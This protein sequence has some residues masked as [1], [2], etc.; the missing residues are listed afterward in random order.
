MKIAII[1]VSILSMAA[2]IGWLIRKH[3]ARQDRLQFRQKLSIVV[4]SLVTGIA[5]YFG[6]LLLALAWMTLR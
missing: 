4:T 3:D 1:L 2:T 5:V 6:L